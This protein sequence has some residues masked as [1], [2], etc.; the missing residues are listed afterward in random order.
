MKKLIL[1]LTLFCFSIIARSQTYL[2]TSN[3]LVAN[4][5]A[6]E[7]ANTILAYG[8]NY[9]VSN[10]ASFPIVKWILRSPSDSLVIS[11]IIPSGGDP[12]YITVNST[13]FG[14]IKYKRKLLNNNPNF[15]FIEFIK[16]D[17][18]NGLNVE[19]YASANIFITTKIKFVYS[20]ALVDR[21][22]ADS[23]QS[24]NTI[25][26]L[27]LQLANKHDTVYVEGSVGASL[28]IKLTGLSSSGP[29]INQI[30]MYPNPTN[31]KIF[32]ELLNP[33]FYTVSITGMSGGIVITKETMGQIDMS[34][35]SNGIYIVTIKDKDGKVVS[36][37]N[38]II[39]Q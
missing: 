20:Q 5:I 36:S 15:Y 38:K 10:S 28:I 23:I 6:L 29:I 26:S 7:S 16:T 37:N 39:K 18:F 13:P 30:K 1:L 3:P 9:N 21:Y 35:L 4:Y 32:I 14:T 22:K 33:G 24:S 34:G 19:A 27:T 17:N 12:N 2:E 11:G 8:W 25:A 31:D